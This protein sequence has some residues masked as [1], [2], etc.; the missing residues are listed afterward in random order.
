MYIY[1]NN[2][3]KCHLITSQVALIPLTVIIK[4]INKDIAARKSIPKYNVKAFL[5]F[6]CFTIELQ[7]IHPV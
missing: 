5:D 4:Q 6:R 3:T 1:Y 7:K 2:N